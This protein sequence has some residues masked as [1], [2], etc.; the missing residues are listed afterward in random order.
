MVHE[1]GAKF[2]RS[3]PL[4]TRSVPSQVTSFNLNAGLAFYSFKFSSDGHMDRVLFYNNDCKKLDAIQ[5]LLRCAA[6]HFRKRPKSE[7]LDFGRLLYP[8]VDAS[9][10]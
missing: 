4:S 9:F 2:R 10:G 6:Y 8:T 1:A 5:F 3:R 7:R